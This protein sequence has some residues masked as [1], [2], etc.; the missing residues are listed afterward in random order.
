[1]SKVKVGVVGVGRMGT[2]HVGILSELVGVELAAVVDT[3]PK[4]LNTIDKNYG[5]PGF[6][7]HQDLYGKVEVAVVA[8]PTGLHYPITKDLLS[9]GIHV[10]LEK[11]CANDLDQARE[12]FKIAEDKGLTLHIGHVERFNGGSSGVA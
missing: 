5:I 9:A 4:N 7:N 3:D 12:L 10:L 8:V 11:P 2:Y 1:M 6:S